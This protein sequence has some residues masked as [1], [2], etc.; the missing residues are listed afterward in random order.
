MSRDGGGGLEDSADG[1]GTVVG[2][3]VD[4]IVVV[5][6]DSPGSAIT[7]VSTRGGWRLLW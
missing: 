5:V 2:T 3:E 6:G 7:S 1:V 4:G